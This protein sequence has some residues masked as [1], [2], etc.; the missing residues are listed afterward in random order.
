ML[1]ATYFEGF[2][3]GDENLC[4]IRQTILF[5]VPVFSNYHVL[6]WKDYITVDTGYLRQMPYCNQNCSTVRKMTSSLDFKLMPLVLL[7]S[8]RSAWH[9]M[10]V[11]YNI[12]RLSHHSVLLR[13]PRPPHQ[14]SNYSQSFIFL[15]YHVYFY[16][17]IHRDG[18]LKRNRPKDTLKHAQQKYVSQYVI[19]ADSQSSST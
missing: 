17:F 14:G 1:L 11:P 7:F 12:T 3:T 10:T 6:S 15:C 19:P 9:K 5:L 16:F 13:S 4:G 8:D 2:V 18:E